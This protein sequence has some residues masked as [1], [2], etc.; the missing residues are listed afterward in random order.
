M[1][2]FRIYL[3]RADTDEPRMY[4]G[5]LE[6]DTMSKVLDL[7]AQYYEYPHHDLVAVQVSEEPT[8]VRCPYC[9]QLHKAGTIEQCQLK[10]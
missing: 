10:P 2:T 7:A 3:E 6:A 5:M 4:L 1:A 9:N 8:L